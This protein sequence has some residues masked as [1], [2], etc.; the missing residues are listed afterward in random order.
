MEKKMTEL[1]TLLEISSGNHDHLCPR[2]ILGVRIGLAGMAALGFAE[3]PAKKR[4]MV[5]SEIDGCFVDGLSAATQCTVG[6][7]TL[8]VE[9]YGKIAATFVDVKTGTAV[10]V[11]PKLDVRDRAYHFVPNEKRHYFAQLEAYQVMADE[12]LLALQPVELMTPVE[13]IVSRAG[14]RANCSICGE[15]IINE[16]EVF[17]NGLTLCQAC[18]GRGYYRAPFNN[19][20]PYYQVEKEREEFCM[21]R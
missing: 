5:I 10:R 6:H 9:D 18:A 2:Q 3:P 20:N 8:R 11:A 12:E 16:R 13:K 14:V 1:R 17:Q 21:V 4:L 19:A 7:R 15:E